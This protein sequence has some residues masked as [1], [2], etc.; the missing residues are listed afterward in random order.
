MVFNPSFNMWRG[1]ASYF[2]I[3]LF[4]FLLFNI[5]FSWILYFIIC[6][7]CWLLT[8][9][10]RLLIACGWLLI[11]GAA[12]IAQTPRPGPAACQ[13]ADS[14]LQAP[15]LKHLECGSDSKHPLQLFVSIGSD[16]TFPNRF[17]VRIGSDKNSRINFGADRSGYKHIRINIGSG[18]FW[19]ARLRN[20]PD[21]QIRRRHAM[22]PRGPPF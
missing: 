8:V 3:S 12:P 19:L 11:V 13:A 14:K 9:G 10:C 18:R 21:S 16:S 2:V 22:S 5:L 17:S 1:L 20:P 15:Y 4:Y 7:C 6:C